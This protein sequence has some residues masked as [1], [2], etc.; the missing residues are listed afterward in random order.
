MFGFKQNAPATSPLQAKL[1]ALRDR[2]SEL[3]AAEPL[4][5]GGALTQ[6]S[7]EQQL[8]MTGQE[9]ISDDAALSPEVQARLM[10]D[11]SLVREVLK[12]FNVDYD[13]LIKMD[14]GEGQEA[15]P[16]ARAVKAN[17]AV[18]EHVL[19]SAQPVLAALQ[20][21]LGF[22][23]YAE[24]MAKYGDDPQSIRDAIRKEVEAELQATPAP[25]SA[26]SGVPVVSPFSANTR[27]AVVGDAGSNKTP[28]LAEIFNK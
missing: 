26:T 18:L 12:L 13:A 8:A 19:Q 15:T 17:P 27:R 20:V 28:T 23:P 25:E 10:A 9:T 7:G 16:Y 2:L 1:Q 5:A 21:A 11:E 24:F 4:V 22:K 6:G 14:A 3:A